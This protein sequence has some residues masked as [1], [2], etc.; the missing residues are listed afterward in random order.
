VL[1]PHPGWTLAGSDEALLLS[2]GADLRYAVADVPAAVADEVLAAWRAGHLDRTVLSAPAGEVL[3][4]LATA[5]ALR[6]AFS[7]DDER[8][9]ATTVFVGAPV[10][11][12]PTG[13]AEGSVVV[14]V[15]TT[16]TLA[17]LARRAAEVNVPHLVVDVAYH[18]TVS[19]GPLV[20]PG[21]T[22]CAS[23]LAGRISARWG[24]EPPPPEPAAARA[25]VAM[26]IVA[27]EVAKVTAG[28]SRLVN[29]T[30]AVDLDTWRTVEQA[31]LRL[32]WCASC[33]RRAGDGRA[34]PG[35]IDLP[36]AAAER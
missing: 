25:V 16:G 9:P 8:P 13:D 23:C 31:V 32:P 18:H 10:D 7:E 28:T 29:R 2:A 21:Q 11:G 19:L 27:H 24:D 15:R 14:L 6:P 12:Y 17:E 5:G 35:A 4:Q 30:V 1:A 20:V 33:G 3:D 36:W 34:G 26:A 22:A